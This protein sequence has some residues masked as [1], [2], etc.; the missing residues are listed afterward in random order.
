MAIGF[1]TRHMS[2]FWID[3]SRSFFIGSARKGFPRCTVAV[4][5]VMGA[6]T[7]AGCR[8]EPSEPEVITPTPP[9]AQNS[10]ATTTP[11][12]K[13]PTLPYARKVEKQGGGAAGIAAPRTTA[14]A[15][16]PANPGRPP[17]MVP[18]PGVPTPIQ[19]PRGQ[20]GTPGKRATQ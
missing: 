13:G 1:G 4:L 18:V 10:V 5:G 12:P 19:P 8:N 9:A 16:K 3:C 6:L 11:T 20:A 14:P 17:R 2:Q 7:L 15:I